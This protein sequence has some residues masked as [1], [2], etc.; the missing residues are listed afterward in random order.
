MGLSFVE[1]KG[2]AGRDGGSSIE[3]SGGSTGESREE[4]RSCGGG[5]ALM[6]GQK[7]VQTG[8]VGG[9]TRGTARRGGR[10]LE[11]KG[12]GLAERVEQRCA[13]VGA[14]GCSGGEARA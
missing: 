14:E 6:R 1:K 2:K 13:V 5:G 10:A 9:L 3:G 11:K 12:A 7:Y 4:V 8:V